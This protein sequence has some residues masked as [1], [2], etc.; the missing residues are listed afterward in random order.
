[1][2]LPGLIPQ[3]FEENIRGQAPIWQLA[4]ELLKD[5]RGMIRVEIICRANDLRIVEQS[6]IIF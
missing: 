6:S 2:I 4:I 5:K 3:F 1:M